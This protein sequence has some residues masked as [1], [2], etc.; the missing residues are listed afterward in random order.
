VG[1]KWSP[2]SKVFAVLGVVFALAAFSIVRG[3]AAR[4]RRMSASLGGPVAVQVIAHFMPRG[5]VLTSA[6]LIERTYPSSY[7]P[8]G[9]VHRPK[10]AVSR[11][12]LTSMAAGEPLTLDRL[13]PRG[14]GPVAALVPPGLRVVSVPSSLPP[15]AIGAGD[16][17]D[18][19]ATFPGPHA[20]TETTATG[21]EVLRVISAATGEQPGLAATSASGSAPATLLLLVT[22]E[23]TQE[24]AY[25]R[26]FAD[27]SIALDGPEEVTPS[28]GS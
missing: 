27:L 21:I 10:D 17:I 26:A 8:P 23:Q 4:A 19:L 14:A 3:Y 6:M 11:V 2:P 20:H 18:V 13:A 12:L 1:R 28:E 24:L 5:T 15:G 7:A 9:A 16:R 25:V 22:P